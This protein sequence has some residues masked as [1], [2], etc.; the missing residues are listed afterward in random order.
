MQYRTDISAHT[1][2]YERHWHNR[3]GALVLILSLILA[4]IKCG[5]HLE[6]EKNA[7]HFNS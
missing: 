4:L 1:D 6:L 5:F 7:E 2:Y 3:T